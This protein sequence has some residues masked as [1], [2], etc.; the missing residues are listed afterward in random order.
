MVLF[1]IGEVEVLSLEMPSSQIYEEL[2]KSIISK[3]N[4]KCKDLRREILAR[5][6]NYMKDYIAGM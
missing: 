3:G 1:Q 4:F 5:S 2:G 6:R